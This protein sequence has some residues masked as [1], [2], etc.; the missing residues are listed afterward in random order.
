MTI[1]NN[2]KRQIH[3]N[4]IQ[5]TSFSEQLANKTI[6][7]NYFPNIGAYYSNNYTERY[8]ISVGNSASLKM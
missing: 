6:Y 5:M 8:K 4:S 7:I 2:L 3:I 1:N